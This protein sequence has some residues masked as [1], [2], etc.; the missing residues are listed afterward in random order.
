MIRLAAEDLQRIERAAEETYPRECCGL[1]V[2]RDVEG[3]L[4]VEEVVAARNVAVADDAFEVDPQCRIDVERR[5]RGSAS[6][7]IGLYHSHPDYPAVP[8]P[9]DL[10]RA[11]EPDLVWLITAVAA[12]RATGT[13]A[14]KPSADG[15]RFDPV[16]LQIAAVPSGRG[17]EDKR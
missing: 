2:G 1:L 13:R 11:W 14:H 16:R 10:E 4:L 9:R 6:R 5:L 12:G 15:S 7:V 17:K 3:G 8:S